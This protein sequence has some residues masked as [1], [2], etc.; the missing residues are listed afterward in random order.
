MTWNSAK[1]TN[2]TRSA[3]V[4]MK[5]ITEPNAGISITCFDTWHVA[6][7]IFL[8][9]HDFSDILTQRQLIEN[10]A[11][12]KKVQSETRFSVGLKKNSKN[13]QN[14][15][16]WNIVGC[17]LDFPSCDSMWASS[18]YFH[19]LVKMLVKLIDVDE[20]KVYWEVQC[21][22]LWIFTLFPKI[23]VVL[24]PMYERLCCRIRG[25]FIKVSLNPSK[26]WFYTKPET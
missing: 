9:F 19:R 18:Q 2:H 23:S 8:H 16:Q 12:G 10:L 1:R 13:R 22:F 14:P 25:V 7:K 6:R 11:S 21:R 24:I 20:V 15:P 3:N 17:M 4:V 5:T 26:K